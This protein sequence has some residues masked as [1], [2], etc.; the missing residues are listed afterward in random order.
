MTYQKLERDAQRHDRKQ[1][2]LKW[3]LL[4]VSFLVAA[5]AAVIVIHIGHELAV[6]PAAASLGFFCGSFSVSYAKSEKEMFEKYIR[7]QLAR[8]SA[9]RR[10]KIQSEL[11]EACL[12]QISPDRKLSRLELAKS[13]EDAKRHELVLKVELGNFD[14]EYK[15]IVDNADRALEAFTRHQKPGLIEKSDFA[16]AVA[17]LLANAMAL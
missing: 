1:V 17:G 13:I 6:L 11:D 2:F 12:R 15:R 4:V 5:L 3:L 14:R 8:V 16:H 9:E 10:A 7:A